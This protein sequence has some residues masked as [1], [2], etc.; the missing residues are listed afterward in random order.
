MRHR[1]IPFCVTRKRACEPAVRRAALER[2][3]SRRGLSR[4]WFDAQFAAR[5]IA[6]TAFENP[7]VEQV[8]GHPL[9]VG[10]DVRLQRVVIVGLILGMISA[11]AS[12][13]SAAM[14]TPLGTAHKAVR[15]KKI[16]K[17][18]VRP[19]G[20]ESGPRG[21]LNFWS[22]RRSCEAAYAMRD[23]GW[24]DQYRCFGRRG[25]FS[26]L[27]MRCPSW[28]LE[29]FRMN[30]SSMC[31][32]CWVAIGPVNSTNTTHSGFLASAAETPTIFPQAYWPSQSA[33]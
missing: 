17:R 5:L 13:T 23:L 28:W 24:R 16:P 31:L 11:N 18:K 33:V 30:D 3:V 29:Y 4:L 7:A 2:P 10:R 8:D 32:A 20:H 21:G 1:G 9:P 14:R 12:A 15:R 19:G 6:V 26:K 25:F 22:S 27:R